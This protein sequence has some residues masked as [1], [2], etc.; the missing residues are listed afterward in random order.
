MG[1]ELYGASIV[2]S[3]TNFENGRADFEFRRISGWAILTHNEHVAKLLAEVYFHVG[4][5]KLLWYVSNG[6]RR[7]DV[8]AWSQSD[9]IS[10][11][12]PNSFRIEI[13]RIYRAS[14]DY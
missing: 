1:D 5:E 14:G 8:L 11:A 7:L 12:C 13:A 9:S 10:T 3:S 4:I 2:S 6:I